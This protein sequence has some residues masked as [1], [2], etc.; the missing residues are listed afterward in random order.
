[1]FGVS[2]IKYYYSARM[3]YIDHSKD[4]YNFTKYI[5]AILFF[6]IIIR[7]IFEHQIS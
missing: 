4:I 7:N 3:H 6:F 2:K 1:M 5:N